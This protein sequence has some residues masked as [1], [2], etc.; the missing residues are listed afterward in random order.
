[1]KKLLLT[2][3]AALSLL[4][5]AGA[6]AGEPLKWQCGNVGVTVTYKP[7]DDDRWFSGDTEYTL[8]GV[9]KANNRFK[10]T[11]DGLYLNGRVCW[12]VTPITCLRPDGTSEPCESRQVPLPK[13]RP[14]DA[15]EPVPLPKTVLYFEPGAYTA[16]AS[17]R[18]VRR[19]CRNSWFV[20]ISLYADHGLC[21]A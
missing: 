4:N 3:V 11:N 19:R 9:E 18:R 14:A 20:W 1:V 17:T 6:H 10:W 16:L 13:A 7:T 21:P 12:P 15:P 8:T 5:V 2:G